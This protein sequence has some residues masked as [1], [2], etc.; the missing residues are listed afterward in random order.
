[1]D[2]EESSGWDLEGRADL[3][4]EGES[5]ASEVLA[6]LGVGFHGPGKAWG[7]GDPLI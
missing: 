2:V 5:R 4:E 6:L 7:V 1:M 3:C